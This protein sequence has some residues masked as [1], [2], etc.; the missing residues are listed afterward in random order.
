MGNDIARLLGIAV[1]AIETIGGGTVNPDFLQEIGI[2]MDKYTE[3][4][5]EAYALASNDLEDVIN[6]RVTLAIVATR[7]G[8]QKVSPN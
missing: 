8:V 4:Y 6:D 2:D 3:V 5:T 1:A 7:L